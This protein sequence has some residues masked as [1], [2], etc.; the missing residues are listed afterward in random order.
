MA[1]RSKTQ[2]DLIAREKTINEKDNTIKELT[3][4]NLEM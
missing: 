1:A 3:A 2:E 4:K